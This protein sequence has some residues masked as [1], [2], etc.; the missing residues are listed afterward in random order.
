MGATLVML[1]HKLSK[2]MRRVAHSS[3]EERRFTALAWAAGPFVELTLK[4]AGL[5]RTVRLIEQL[6]DHGGGGGRGVGDGATDIAEGDKL[7]RLA[8]RAQPLLRGG[9]LERSL[10]QYALHRLDRRAAR[11]VVGVRRPGPTEAGLLD[12]HAWIEASD[13]GAGATD[14]APLLVREFTP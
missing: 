6:T 3:S 8:Y 7:V 1:L 11:L 4:I 13:G 9:C 14:F 12:A 2:F 5:E 10:V